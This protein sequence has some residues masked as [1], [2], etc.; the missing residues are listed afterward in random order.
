MKSIELPIESESISLSRKELDDLIEKEGKMIMQDKMEK[1][2]A[3]AKNALEEFV[4]EFR[5]RLSG[6]YEKFLKE[7]ERTK[8]GK[9]LE[10][11]ENW[12]YDE[13]EDQ[14]KSVYAQKLV[15]LQVHNKPLLLRFTEYEK[16]PEV[17]SALGSSLMRVQKALE[18]YKANEET[19]NHIPEEEMKKVK[20][21]WEEK[22]AY[23]GKAL[24][25]LSNLPLYVDPPILTDEIQRQQRELE[26]VTGEILSK[27]KPTVEPPAEEKVNG[28][29]QPQ[30]NDSEMPDS[31]TNATPENVGKANAS[32]SQPQCDENMETN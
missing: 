14:Q 20:K 27:P 2:R 11:T 31:T 7:E 5:D 15:D 10:D 6:L 25:R 30:Q 13:G 18:S 12:L 3:D 29:A 16:R 19:Y 8:I 23:Y 17:L 21:I 9:I 26:Q 24:Q 4:Y 28:P 1:E 22:Q 32:E